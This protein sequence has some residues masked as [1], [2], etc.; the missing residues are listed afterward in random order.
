MTLGHLASPSHLKIKYHQMTISFYNIYFKMQEKDII[1]QVI[2]EY[3]ND[4]LFNHYSQQALSHETNNYYTSQTSPH[5][6]HQ[7]FKAATKT[8]SIVP[9]SLCFYF[10]SRQNDQ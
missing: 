2:S 5:A 7:R 8:H 4:T 1:Y 3:L 10:A 6:R 9:P